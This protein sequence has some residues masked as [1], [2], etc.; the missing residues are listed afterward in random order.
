[1]SLQEQHMQRKSPF[2]AITDIG[3]R[4]ARWKGGYW[5]QLVQKLASTMVPHMWEIL[6]DPDLSHAFANFRIAAGLEKGEHSGPPFFDGD[7][8]KWL[9][10]AALA[11]AATGDAAL[12]AL[13]DEAIAVIA[14]SQREDGYIHSPVVIVERT[15]RRPEGELTDRLNFEVYNMGHLM[16]AA[17]RHREATGKDSLLRV[18]VRAADFLKG[19]FAEPSPA[20]A[21]NNICPSHIMGLIDLYRATGDGSY[22]E[23]A[24]SC[25]AIRDLIED[26]TDDNQ[27]RIPF[28]RQRA[29][30][31][32]AVR[33]NYLYA[34]A[35]DVYAE[36]GDEG[37]LPA[38]ESLWRDVV[39]RKMYLTGACGALF[40]GVS[41][42]G[43][44]DHQ[45]IQRVHQAYGREYQ[46]PNITAYN[47]VCAS[48]GN[49]LWNWRM[50]K[51]R[52]E[53]RFMD[54]VET[55]LYNG[56]PVGISLDGMRYFYRTAL[57]QPKELPFSLRWPRSR[58]SYLSSFCCPPNV[59]RAIGASSSMAYAVSEDGLWV[60]LYG[61]GSVDTLLPDGS[62]VSVSQET[63]YPWEGR[64]TLRVEAAPERVMSL[65]LRVP[66]WAEGARLRL[67]SGG[68]SEAL[69]AE[70]GEYAAVERRFAAGDEL[71][72]ELPMEPRL[73]LAN[74][75]VEETRNQVAI[76]RGPIVYCL[77]SADL[78][79]GVSL[80]D[81]VV[82][83]DA[84]LAPRPGDGVL[85]GT[86]VLEG[87]VLR[88]VADSL[89][90]R[91]YASV[92]PHR[93]E[94]IDA[95]FIPYYAWDNR[96]LSE[97]SVWLP[98]R[99]A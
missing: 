81:I 96:G 58:A 41:P 56:L 1:M 24:A 4:D 92:P 30:V 21:K 55:V 91:L 57:R 22:R 85:A 33:A 76:C 34:G 17:C 94:A 11:F 49:A 13:M 25:L 39:E 79:E 64:V 35:A 74:E 99:W 19:Y 72:L 44:E 28:K 15:G 71:V 88:L 75:L 46:L 82:P 45:S 89:G 62:R 63:D 7:L 16:T 73:T 26:G 86:T 53:A 23:L 47:E 61:S 40:D 10:A 90:D 31:G 70:A 67:V 98:L 87:E 36:T 6:D 5:G 27:D 52:G 68:M 14:A 38:L 42:D 18:A 59:L 12:D 78:P 3:I 54:V 60:N 9:E 95:R 65:R 51:L 48:V 66:A 84:A 29:A 97:M 8:Y 2:A 77:E 43:A 37:Y 80:D 50:F 83:S 93:L 20:I 69:K 32:H